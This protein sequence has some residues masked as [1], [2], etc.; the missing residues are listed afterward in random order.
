MKLT[1]N[2]KR[3]LIDTL[4]DTIGAED[5]TPSDDWEYSPEKWI[6]FKFTHNQFERKR[7]MDKLRVNN[8]LDE[9]A[10]KEAYG[11]HE[12]TM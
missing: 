8:K 6:P 4:V 10:Y 12:N 5:S 3:I 11:N 2:E 9:L 1:D 7:I